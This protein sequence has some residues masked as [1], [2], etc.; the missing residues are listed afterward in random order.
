ML[1][2]S[3][4]PLS[5]PLSVVG[6][7]DA[8]LY[9]SVDVPDADIALKLVDV[10]P[11]GRAFNLYDTMLRLRYRDGVDQPR[12]L[13]KDRVYEVKISGL[14]TSNHFP[15]GHRV[16]LEVAGSNFPNFERNLHTGGR[17]FDE[18]KGAVAAIRIH[19]SARYPSRIELPTIELAE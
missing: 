1:V 14:I 19:H 2:Y 10:Y 6:E 7:V 11:D 12:L 16:R 9:V 13:Q 4:D 18:T 15:A 3:T 5:A 17:N 8:T